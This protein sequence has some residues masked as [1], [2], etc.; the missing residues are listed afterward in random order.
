MCAVF[1]PAW[2][3]THAW[4]AGAPAGFPDVWATAGRATCC[5]DETGVPG[6]GLDY[7]E[8]RIPRPLFKRFP[9]CLFAHAALP[10]RY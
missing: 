7:H 1:A 10:W 9:Q 4:I 3:R 6:H 5:A 8:M 2:Q